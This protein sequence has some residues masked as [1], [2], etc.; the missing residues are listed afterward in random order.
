MQCPQ[1][2]LQ[3]CTNI[4]PHQDTTMWLC[5]HHKKSQRCK[6]KKKQEKEKKQTD[7]PLNALRTPDAVHPKRREPAGCYNVAKRAG[8]QRGICSQRNAQPAPRRAG[9][10]STA[11]R[12][13]MGNKTPRPV[14]R[15]R[16][17]SSTVRAPSGH[18]LLL[19]NNLSQSGNKTFFFSFHSQRDET[20]R[21]WQR[22]TGNKRRVKFAR[23]HRGVKR[24]KSSVGARL[25]FL[26]LFPPHGR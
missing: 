9:S 1:I 2:L 18:S 5:A 20:P 26:N 6:K 15:S 11:H 10:V 23:T 7:I 4:T 12:R 24:R 13:V 17:R 8:D 16:L 14:A 22:R 19:R 25:L 3:L 21:G